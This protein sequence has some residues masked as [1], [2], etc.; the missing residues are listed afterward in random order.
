M[1]HHHYLSDVAPTDVVVGDSVMTWEEAEDWCLKEHDAHL[2]SIHDDAQ[3]EAVLTVCGPTNDCWIG[4]RRVDD[5]DGAFV[6]SDGTEYGFM[7]W[8]EAEADSECI[9]LDMN[10]TWIGTKCDALYV[11]LCGGVGGEGIVSLQFYK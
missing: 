2:V 9:P 7:P 8:T 1:L 10:G 11:P 3:N 4:A 5:T 6:W